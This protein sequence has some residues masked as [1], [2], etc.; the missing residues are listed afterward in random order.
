MY[1]TH[2]HLQDL[3][4]AGNLAAVM[5]RGRQTGVT[6]MLCC[7]TKPDDWST[8][9]ALVSDYSEVIP[10]FGIHPWYVDDVVECDWKSLLRKYLSK[11]PKAAVGEIGLDFA[12]KP[13]CDDLQMEI[14]LEQLKLAEE[15]ERPV[16]VHCLHAWGALLEVLGN[17]KKVRHG[18]VIHSFS[19]SPET[20][21]QL[22]KYGVYFSFSGSITN[23]A[24]IS[25]A[26]LVQ[27]VPK[28]RLLIETDAPDMMPYSL[29][30]GDCVNEPSNLALVAEKIAEIRG[31]SIED[32][33]KI[34]TENARRVFC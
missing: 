24:Y 28:E 18:M 31:I 13:R 23:P 14:F 32:V 6:Q 20:V 26:A 34:T 7:G 29:K 8:V 19:G 33:V 21:R 5:D 2:C 12:V 4:F 3:R 11:N 9:E 10:A 1:D 25:A 27:S 15:F 30:E 17:I 16:S 22:M